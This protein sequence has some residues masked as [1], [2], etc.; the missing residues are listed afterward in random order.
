[1]VKKIAI[2]FILLLLVSLSS[3]INEDRVCDHCHY[4]RQTHPHLIGYVD[5]QIC[6][7]C[8]ETYLRGEWGEE[9]SS[10]KD[11]VE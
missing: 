6:E 10:T 3:C 1:M 5:M 11:A 8:Y 7:E 4:L 9:F 2:V